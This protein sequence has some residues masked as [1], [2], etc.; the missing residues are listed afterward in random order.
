MANI[1][2]RTR[3]KVLREKT[4][5]LY[6]DGGPRGEGR[7]RR[8]SGGDRVRRAQPGGAQG[9]AR[10]APRCVRVG[11]REGAEESDAFAGHAPASRTTTRPTLS[12]STSQS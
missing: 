3:L 4:F 7:R 2:E 5:G 8:G 9:A 11:A 10:G 6:L 1:G 12:P